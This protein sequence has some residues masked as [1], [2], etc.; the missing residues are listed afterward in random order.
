V[1]GDEYGEETELCSVTSIL[2][3]LAEKP[4]PVLAY[5][6][7]EVIL[8]KSREQAIWHSEV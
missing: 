5:F 2:K 1:A 8:D 7:Y 3:K 4:E 6:Y